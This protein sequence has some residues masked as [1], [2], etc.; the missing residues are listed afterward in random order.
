MLDD[1]P[2]PSQSSTTTTDAKPRRPPYYSAHVF[3]AAV[4]VLIASVVVNYGIFFGSGFSFD[5]VCT[6]TPRE[7]GAPSNNTLTPFIRGGLPSVS[8][9]AVMNL[10]GYLIL[11][12]GLLACSALLLWG[13]WLLHGTIEANSKLWPPS[14]PSAALGCAVLG[15][16]C[17]A[18]TG[19]LSMRIAF[20][21]HYVV[22]FF[23]FS[24]LFAHLC[25]VTYCQRRAKL[26]ERLRRAGLIK[27][28][29][30]LVFVTWSVV[31]FFA[32]AALTRAFPGTSVTLRYLWAPWEL[33]AL[34]A[35][36]AA[37]RLFACD[38]EEARARAVSEALEPVV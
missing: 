34:L 11:L 15:T 17:L 29:L 8:A 36:S 38:L 4:G 32:S 1:A 2:L 24:G 6:V 35:Y 3:H 21:A 13:A 5:D 33:S 27:R 26:D 10:A 20:M 37:C 30:I 18:L 12:L 16:T 19:I 23:G 9:C 14:Y 31:I 28:R 22:A 7:C 25:L